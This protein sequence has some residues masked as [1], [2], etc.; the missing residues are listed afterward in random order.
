MFRRTGTSS[1][2]FVVNRCSIF[3]VKFVNVFVPP[4]ANDNPR[5]R[6]IFLQGFKS[7]FNSIWIQR[8]RDLDFQYWANVRVS[9]DPFQ[10]NSIFIISRLRVCSACSNTSAKTNNKIMDCDGTVS[11]RNLSREVSG[12]ASLS[13][14]Q[15]LWQR[16]E[17]LVTTSQQVSLCR[18]VGRRRFP[19]KRQDFRGESTIQL[20]IHLRFGFARAGKRI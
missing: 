5:L 12:F 7:E 16:F 3:F 15:V 8:V 19:Y 14:S 20:F 2:L 18:N 9:S 1:H 13:C 11:T 10:R 4:S 6:S 17:S